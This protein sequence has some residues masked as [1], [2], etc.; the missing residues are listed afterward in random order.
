MRAKAEEER[1]VRNLKKGNLLGK[2]EIA[3]EKG[4]VTK[5][6][7][8]RFLRRISVG[9]EFYEPIVITFG[10]NIEEALS[11]GLEKKDVPLSHVQLYDWLE[12]DLVNQL[13]SLL[14][15]S[16]YYPES[17]ARTG[18]TLSVRLAFL[19]LDFN[20]LENFTSPWW[21]IHEIQYH[22]E[23]YGEAEW[24]R[25]RN[26]EKLE[27]ASIINDSE[28][29]ELLHRGGL[30]IGFRH[31]TETDYRAIAIS[32]DYTLY[33]SDSYYDLGM[34]KGIL[35]LVGLEDWEI[36]QALAKVDKNTV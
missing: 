30:L 13:S 12:K 9:R 36:E 8:T 10:L 23:V 19:P 29:I 20:E 22:S 33:Q 1:I 35:D 7:V 32:Q 6:E 21:E 14:S 16:F 15:C 17:S 4:I 5:A 11:H 2:L 28:F 27:K 3:L 31:I 26:K 34:W 24:T 25:Q 18:E